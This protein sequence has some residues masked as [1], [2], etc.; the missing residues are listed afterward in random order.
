MRERGGASYFKQTIDLIETAFQISYQCT[1]PSEILRMSRLVISM[2]TC[3]R[4]R[5]DHG[6]ATVVNLFKLKLPNDI[7]GQSC[8]LAQSV[9]LFACLWYNP[10]ATVL[11][12]DK[13]AG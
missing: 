7:A 9:G 12:L 6:L 1:M 10:I 13:E 8:N 11:H 3:L 2:L 5:I 4:G